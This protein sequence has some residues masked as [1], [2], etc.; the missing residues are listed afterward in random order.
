[1]KGNTMAK[2][3]DIEPVVLSLKLTVTK[4]TENG[5]LGGVTDV[6]VVSANGEADTRFYGFAS[7]WGSLVM[8]Y[9]SEGRPAKPAKADKPAPKALT[10]TQKA[11]I[12]ANGTKAKGKAKAE[13]AAP[14]APATIAGFTPEQLA[15]LQALKDAGIL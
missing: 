4:A 8:N 1:M 14:A 3:F 10:A 13:P 12:P 2:M 5:L 11:M 15:K 9:K 7:N 6:E